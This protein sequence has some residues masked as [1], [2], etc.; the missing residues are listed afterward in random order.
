MTATTGPLAWGYY[1]SR[2]ERTCCVAE[3]PGTKIREEVDSI[4]PSGYSAFR[5]LW[6]VVQREPWE[7]QWEAKTKQQ[8]N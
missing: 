6:F 8:N 7:N 4:Q 2:Q 5:L 1:P 3:A